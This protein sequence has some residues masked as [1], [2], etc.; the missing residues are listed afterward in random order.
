MPFIEN[1]QQ[2]CTRKSNGGQKCTASLFKVCFLIIDYLTKES[3]HFVAT[4]S[5]TR[6]EICSWASVRKKFI[7]SLLGGL[8]W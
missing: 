7:F 1:F 2:K 4:P 6:F 5:C 3:C 8:H